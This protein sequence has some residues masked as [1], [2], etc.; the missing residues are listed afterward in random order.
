M[1]HFF[2]DE[3]E[4]FRAQYYR[5]G[6]LEELQSQMETAQAE[7][8]KEGA[9]DKER[10]EIIKTG[11]PL[12]AQLTE[13]DPLQVEDSAWSEALYHQLDG[14]FIDANK[15]LS[16]RSLHYTHEIDR[17]NMRLINELGKDGLLSLK[18]DHH[19]LFLQDLVLNSS[20]TKMFRIVDHTIVPKV[21]QIYLEPATSNGRAPFYSH[22]KKVGKLKIPTLWYNLGVLG[23]MAVLTALALFFRIPARFMG[24]KGE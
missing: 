5:I 11:L 16:K 2:D 6:F 14:Y 22:I 12:L 17:T 24:K 13:K 4:K 10:L 21:G 1:K 9:P 7:Y 18:K 8:L 23:I 3:K 19:N 20:S 15:I